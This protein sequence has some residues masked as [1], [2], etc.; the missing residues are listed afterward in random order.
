MTVPTLPG[1]TGQAVQ[2]AHEVERAL[3]VRRTFHVHAHEIID[4]HR[5]V[6]QFGDQPE[7]QLFAHVKSHVREL[8]AD[9]GVQLA[10]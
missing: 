7:G 9:I 5:V 1:V 6:H 8:Q 3:R 10:G 2:L 4:A